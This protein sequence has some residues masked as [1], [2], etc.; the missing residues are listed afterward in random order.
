MMELDRDDCQ[1][2][3]S[4]VEDVDDATYSLGDL[5]CGDVQLWATDLE[6]TS[7]VLANLISYLHA[8]AAAAIRKASIAPSKAAEAIPEP[9]IDNLS[10]LAEK[11]HGGWCL[12]AVRRELEGARC[13]NDNLLQLI[14]LFGKDAVT[15]L[16]PCLENSGGPA[17]LG[18][19]V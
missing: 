1:S 9:V 13:R 6:V 14:P 16:Q 8:T 10:H 19:S 12:V 18:S 2:D 5:S 17:W 7:A 4:T 15:S 3:E 11:Y